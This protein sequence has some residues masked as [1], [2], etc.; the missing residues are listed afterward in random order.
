MPR[1]WQE[2]GDVVVIRLFDE[3][4]WEYRYEVGRILREVTGARSVV[5]L[6]RV[7]G[8][9]REPLGEVV[10]GD[11]SAETVHRELGIRFKLDPTRVMFARGNLGERRRLLES[12]LEGELVF[13][14]F[15]GIG[16]FTLPAA[17]AGA[18]VVATELNP[19]AYRYLV[20][21]VRLNDVEGRVRTFLG[22]CREVARFVQDA[23]RVLM[24]YLK[25]TLKFLP[26]ACRAV[27]NGGILI[28]HEVFRKRWGEDRV[29]RE[30]LNALPEGFEG[31]V[32]EVRRVKSFS[33]ALDHYAVELRVRRRR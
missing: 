18:E 15:A 22:D 27:R 30:V 21:N 3:R 12:D 28:V 31:E 6:R 24:G 16:Y 20:E 17:L 13:D 26:Y 25:G 9:F 7:S 11:R 1:R 5:A 19:V 33:P 14:M 2:L 4:A 10:A 8:V 23:D 29:T 32:V